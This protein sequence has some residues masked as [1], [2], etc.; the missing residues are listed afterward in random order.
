MLGTHYPCLRAVFTASFWTH[1]RP[2]TRESFLDTRE[3]GP[4]RS[5]GAVVND[6]V[7]FYL[8]DGCPKWHRCSGAVKCE[9]VKCAPA[10]IAMRVTDKLQCVLN[11]AVVVG[12]SVAAR[13][14]D[15]AWWSSVAR[16]SWR[17]ICQVRSWSVS[18]RPRTCT[19]TSCTITS[20][21]A[22]LTVGDIRV[23]PWSP[24]Y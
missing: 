21:S 13:R 10:F 11:A 17:R 4:S 8:Q 2:W 18:E 19:V 5:A 20:R 7:Y 3:H 12:T 6:V 14:S 1:S 9:H 23:Q 22:L 15:T 24:I 16:R